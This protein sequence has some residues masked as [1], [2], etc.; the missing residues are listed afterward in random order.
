MKEDVW[1]GKDS[2][3]GNRKNCTILIPLFETVLH[4]SAELSPR[5]QFSVTKSL[6]SVTGK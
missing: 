1:L 3:C 6:F 5:D 2:E 4:Q